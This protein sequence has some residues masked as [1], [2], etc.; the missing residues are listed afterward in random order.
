MGLGE[1]GK[2]KKKDVR[3][4]STSNPPPAFGINHSPCTEHFLQGPSD[5]RDPPVNDPKLCYTL[6]EVAPSQGL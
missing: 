6:R 4:G 1:G 2:K 3:S 5:Q